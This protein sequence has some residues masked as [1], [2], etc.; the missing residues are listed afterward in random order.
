MGLGFV[1]LKIA[2]WKPICAIQPILNIFHFLINLKN[3]IKKE[4]CWTNHVMPTH[5]FEFDKKYQ[6]L[7]FSI[8]ATATTF[9]MDRC[10][11]FHKCQTPTLIHSKSHVDFKYGF[12]F[13]SSFSIFQIE[14]K[15]S[16]TLTFQNEIKCQIWRINGQ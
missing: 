4:M 13:S 6:Q 7:I 15:Y 1:K 5:I 10:G 8:L 16:R 2:L 3:K 9:T 12:N 14:A 11:V